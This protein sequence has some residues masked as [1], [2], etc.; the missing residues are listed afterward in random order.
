MTPT[1][2][3]PL[4]ERE[5]ETE[6]RIR[7]ALSAGGA[8]AIDAAARA[9]IATRL[10]ILPRR[11]AWSGTLMATAAGIAAVVVAA[12]LGGIWLAGRHAPQGNL[13]GGTTRPGAPS[14]PASPTPGAQ[15]ARFGRL[16]EIS[17]ST[18]AG[19]VVGPGSGG[20]RVKLT[21]TMAA[22]AVTPPPTT[23]GLV[24]RTAYPLWTRPDAQRLAT[25]LGFG[26]APREDRYGDRVAWTWQAGNRRA[27][28]DSLGALHY[29]DGQPGAVTGRPP[30][31]LA[32][33]ALQWLEQRGLRPAGMDPTPAVRAIGDGRV[34]LRFAGDAISYR[35]PL[36]GPF[37]VLDVVVYPDGQVS[38]VDLRWAAVTG[39]S[40]YPLRAS[41]DIAQRLAAGEGRLRIEPPAA[42]PAGGGS[43]VVTEVTLG[44]ALATRGDARVVYIE[45]VYVIR[46]TVTWSGG[47]SAPFVAVLS[48][49]D[50]AWVEPP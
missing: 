49:I 12:S 19:G 5:R 31:E 45:P 4:D 48:A 22:G 11:R 41:A 6:A 42:N 32:R 36:D 35:A 40:A 14:S 39:T 17:A 38:A 9:R 23:T 37:P 3:G 33:L 28:V 47:H 8:T 20:P 46:G 16:P 7:R 2:S 24:V 18:A 27:E 30:G 10:A 13:P 50:P 43:G 29:T 26:G 15:V 1:P 21:F 25:R 34:E 44:S